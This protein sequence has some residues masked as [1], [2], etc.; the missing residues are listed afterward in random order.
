MRKYLVILGI[1]LC[2][3]L[4]SQV[5][6]TM[7][8]V[9]ISYWNHTTE[10]YDYSHS[11]PVAEV[12]YIHDDIVLHLL[13]EY[14]FSTIITEYKEDLVTKTHKYDMI[15]DQ[16]VNYFMG[17]NITDRSLFIISQN[18]DVMRSYDIKYMQYKK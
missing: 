17:I 16:G 9:Y 4:Q 7:H 10:S 6:F 8:T 2:S 3:F 18:S 13:G 1:L 11:E 14:C 5:I 15:D 12:I